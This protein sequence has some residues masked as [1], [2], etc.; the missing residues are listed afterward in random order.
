M[1][2]RGFSNIT[3]CKNFLFRYAV[4]AQ[5]DTF[6]PVELA[7]LAGGISDNIMISHDVFSENEWAVVRYTFA[8][9]PTRVW[10]NMFRRSLKKI[11]RIL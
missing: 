2:G 9:L 4:H 7:E 5:I 1:T 10:L 3:L 11:Y 8:P 6:Q